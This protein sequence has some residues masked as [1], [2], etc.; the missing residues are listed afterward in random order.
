VLVQR[1]MDTAE[2]EMT[3]QQLWALFESTYLAIDLDT[4]YHAHHLF[5][6]ATGKAS[7]SR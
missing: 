7:R 4:A 1:A 2:T 6:K 5:E 3:S